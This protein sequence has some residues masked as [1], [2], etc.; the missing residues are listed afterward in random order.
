MTDFCF[1]PSDAEIST[2]A[3]EFQT[4]NDYAFVGADVKFTCSYTKP[5]D[6]AAP[7]VTWTATATKGGTAIAVGTADNSAAASTPVSLL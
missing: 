4:G 5:D 1:L 2:D 3:T 6:L 7:T